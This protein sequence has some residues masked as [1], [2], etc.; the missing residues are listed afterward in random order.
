MFHKVNVLM[1]LDQEEQ[2]TVLLGVCWTIDIA[3]E[4]VKILYD[5]DNLE[6][7]QKNENIFIH[8]LGELKDIVLYTNIEVY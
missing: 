6:W 7:T 2:M 4:Y 1:L 3:E 8:S 5:I